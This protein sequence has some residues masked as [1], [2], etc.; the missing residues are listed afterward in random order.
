[1]GI[2]FG[3]VFDDTGTPYQVVTPPL[4][5]FRIRVESF[6]LHQAQG[7]SG[8]LDESSRAPLTPARRSK[9]WCV[10][11]GSVRFGG[12]SSNKRR[13]SGQRPSL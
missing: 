5:V 3:E 10:R 13:T 9:M 7:F 2:G 8:S 12:C 1:M 4:H 11:S 6:I